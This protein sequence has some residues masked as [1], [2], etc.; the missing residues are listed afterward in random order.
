MDAR[1]GRVVDSAWLIVAVIAVAVALVI[2][3]PMRKRW[4]DDG[5]DDD[6]RQEQT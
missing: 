1:S 4:N 3:L 5:A 6:K 2:W